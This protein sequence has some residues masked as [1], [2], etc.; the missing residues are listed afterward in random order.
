MNRRSATMAVLV[1]MLLV[2]SGC[3]YSNPNRLSYYDDD[4]RIAQQGDSY[5]FSNRLGRTVANELALSFT[6]FTGKQTIWLIPAGQDCV[7]ELDLNN[8]ITGGKF[9]VC[10]IDPNRQVSVIS[11]GSQT[12]TINL[13]IPKGENVLTIVGSKASGTVA[14]TLRYDSRAAIIPYEYLLR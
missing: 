11:E 4:A 9:K 3:R 14:M 6:D 13:N 8:E 7:L 5:T 10:L 12:G 1:L 2:L